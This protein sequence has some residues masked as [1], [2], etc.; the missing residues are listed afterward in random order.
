MTCEPVQLPHGQVNASKSPING[1]YPHGTTV[2][3]SCNPGYILDPPILES[4]CLSGVHWS[5]STPTCRPGNV[6]GADNNKR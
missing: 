1:E 3:F 2:Y 5:N 4:T 6:Q